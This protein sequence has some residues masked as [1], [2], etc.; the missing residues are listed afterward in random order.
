[1]KK[2]DSERAKL[3]NIRY[4]GLQ[5]YSMMEG[6]ERVK[7]GMRLVRHSSAGG[8]NN[9]F[10]NLASTYGKISPLFQDPAEVRS[11]LS[12]DVAF[13]MGWL[14]HYIADAAQP[15][16]SIRSTTM[17]GLERTRKAIRARRPST[18]ASNRL[19]WI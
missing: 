16:L 12:R 5:A 18:A 9:R 1:M 7:A 10:G 17:A 15:P 19:T 4:T 2:T 11:F 14:G 3:L 6:Y 13:Y 8:E